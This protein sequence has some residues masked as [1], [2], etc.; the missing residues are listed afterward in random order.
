MSKNKGATQFQ[1]DPVLNMS[2]NAARAAHLAKVG[3]FADL[4][5]QPLALESLSSAMRT[6][7]FEPHVAMLTEGQTGSELFVLVQGQ[8]SVYKST[9]QGDPYK[10]AIITGE[11]NACFGEGGLLG[12]EARSATIKTDTHCHCLVLERAAFEAFCREHP[13][14][15]MPVILRI[16]HAMMTRLRKANNDMMLLYNALVA[17]IRGH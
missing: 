15:A 11:Q 14:W 4:A 13:Q 6:R 5:G 12:S 17:E 1:S 7:S 16:A 3:L 8:A 10:V 2:D 9:P